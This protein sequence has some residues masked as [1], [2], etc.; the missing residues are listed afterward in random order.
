MLVQVYSD[1][2]C[3][4]CYIG[5][6]RFERAVAQ[7]PAGSIDVFWKPFQ[8]DPNAPQA[9]S[10]VFDAYAKKFG[11]PEQA[12]AIIQRVTDVAADEGIEF[13]MD[14]AQRANTFNAHRLLAWAAEDGDPA[15]LASQGR[16]K[17][18]LLNAYFCAGVD[19]ANIDNLAQIAQTVGYDAA[20][21]TELLNGTDGIDDCRAEI[22]T[23]RD[24]GISAV[25]T[26]VFAG[27][28]PD[29]VFALPGA[30]DTDTFVKILQRLLN[31][32]GG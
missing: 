1:V 25:P 21:V 11:G 29:N 4:W 23:G 18:A 15:A 32:S 20:V 22:Q 14:R 9:P 24:L 7:L 26:F 10:P 5:K 27:D 16:L 28:T 13:R 3:P 6:R 12:T 31:R 2:V 19:V 17:E 8:L 30:Q